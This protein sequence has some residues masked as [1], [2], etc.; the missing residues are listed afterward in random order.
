M[1]Y[2]NFPNF[3]AILFRIFYFFHSEHL[4]RLTLE[5]SVDLLRTFGFSGSC[6]GFVHEVVVVP[7]MRLLCGTSLIEIEILL[8]K[9]FI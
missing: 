5:V 3:F 1:I 8:T 6:D 9:S 2:A 4:D 7:L